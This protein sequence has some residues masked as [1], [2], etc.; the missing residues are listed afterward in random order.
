LDERDATDRLF[1]KLGEGGTVTTPLAIQPW[2]GY[3]G[4]LTDRFGVQWMLEC[5]DQKLHTEL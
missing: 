5:P 1:A 2:G 3:Y 4:K